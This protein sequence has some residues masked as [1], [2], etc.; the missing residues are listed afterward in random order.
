MATC[1]FAIYLWFFSTKISQ[2]FLQK[3]FESYFLYVTLLAQLISLIFLTFINVDF[4][5]SSYQYLQTINGQ[6]TI[7]KKLIFTILVF[8]IQFLFYTFLIFSTLYQGVHI[9]IDLKCSEEFVKL[10]VI[11]TNILPLIIAIK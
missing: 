11:Q 5:R 9:M 4:F 2:I 1:L 8:S 10:Y 6:L 3:K 7:S